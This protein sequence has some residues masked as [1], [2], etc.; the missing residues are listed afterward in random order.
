MPRNPLGQSGK[1]HNTLWL[2]TQILFKRCLLF[3]LGL[4]NG[5]KRKQKQRLFKIWVDKQRV[6]WYF[7]LQPIGT[8]AMEEAGQGIKLDCGIFLI[9][10]RAAQSG[11]E[12]LLSFVSFP[13]KRKVSI[14][15]RTNSLH[16]VV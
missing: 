6:L 12:T 13:Q 9:I 7:P 16:G 4:N 1:Y 15:F 8:P 10:L 3:L 5:P 11:N 2:S 14:L